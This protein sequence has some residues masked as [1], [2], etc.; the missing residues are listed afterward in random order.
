MLRVGRIIEA[1]EAEG[2]GLRTAVWLQGCTLG[3]PGCCNP[4]LLPTR[5]APDHGDV[6]MDPISLGAQLVDRARRPAEAAIEGVT[7][8]GGEPLQQAVPLA[9]CIAWV[10]EHS[11][12][13]VMLFTGYRYAQ[14]VADPDRR[15]VLELC[16]LVVAGPF[17][18]AHAPD[19]R[20]WI[21][22]SNQTVHFVTD[23]YAALR[24]AWE[25]YR[26]EIEVHV[27]DGEIVVNGTPLAE[28][29][30]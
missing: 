13:G 8:L 2:P 14:V 19:S 26:R 3:C 20:R 25:P 30:L 17:S 29:L 18:R 6:D 10:R 22:S 15:R 21:G 12:L 5:G 7:F 23:R 11:S 24:T 16:D 28:P 4:E 9:R 27:R 1:T